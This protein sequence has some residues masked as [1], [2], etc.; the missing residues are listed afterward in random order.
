MGAVKKGVIPRNVQCLD[1]LTD[2]AA[3]STC[4]FLKERLGHDNTQEDSIEMLCL[5]L[6]CSSPGKGCRGNQSE[7][8]RMV[9]KL[10]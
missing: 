2:R 6:G 7:W 9:L 5:P 4:F 3:G 1:I 8:W 10:T